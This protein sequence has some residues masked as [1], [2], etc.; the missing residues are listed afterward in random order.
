MIEDVPCERGTVAEVAELV[1]P[2]MGTI[3]GDVFDVQAQKDPVNLAYSQLGLELHQ[4]LAYY[5]SPPGIQLLHCVEFGDAIQGGES[6][7]MDVMAVAEQFREICPAAF[8]ILASVPATLHKVH[9]ARDTPVHMVYQRPHVTTATV[10]KLHRPL[11]AGSREGAITTV[12]WAPV[13]EGPLCV[14]PS[15]VEAYYEAYSA[16]ARVIKGRERYANSGAPNSG[17]FIKFKLKPGDL[18]MFNNRRMLHGREAF[19][20]KGAS[21]GDGEATARHLQ[22]CYINIDEYKSSLAFMTAAAQLE[23]AGVSPSS[24]QAHLHAAAQNVVVKR[25]GN[26]CMA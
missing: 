17:A 22:G 1:A 23:A 10:D 25:V 9:Y 3:Y 8:D 24:P 12:S 20:I 16:F 4:D 5:E 6:T 15:A 7:L 19:G 2:V 21:E 13:F 11:P 14:H 18:V 26:Q